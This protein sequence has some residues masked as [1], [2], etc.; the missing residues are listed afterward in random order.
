MFPTHHF[1]GPKHFWSSHLS[2]SLDPKTSTVGSARTWSRTITASQSELEKKVKSLSTWIFLILKDLTWNLQNLPMGNFVLRSPMTGRSRT[3]HKSMKSCSQ[4][5]LQKMEKAFRRLFLK[6][7]NITWVAW[8]VSQSITKRWGG[9]Y[10]I[11]KILLE[12]K[13]EILIP[14][15]LPV[16]CCGRSAF[17]NQDRSSSL[18]Q[19]GAVDKLA[20][21]ILYNNIS[22]FF[23]V[24]FPLRPAKALKIF[25]LCLS[26]FHSPCIASSQFSKGCDKKDCWN[27]WTGNDLYRYGIFSFS[28][29]GDSGGYIAI[30]LAGQL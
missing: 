3:S 21:L 18:I 30:Y 20:F 26:V 25:P 15:G 29:A 1:E 8:S 23:C 14:C 22:L 9:K 12:I 7:K 13:I 24:M 28:V 4:K 10:Q 11:K 5:S 27:F 6:V 19:R 16:L 17:A 2:T